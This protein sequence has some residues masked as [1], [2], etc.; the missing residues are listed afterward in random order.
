M[1]DGGE[2]HRNE[3]GGTAA[4]VAQIANLYGN[5][6]YSAPERLADIPRQNLPGPRHYTNNERQLAELSEAGPVLRLVR[7]VPGSGRSTLC[8]VH[9]AENLDRYPDGDF[10]ISLGSGPARLK[11]ALATLLGEVLPGQDLPISVEGLSARWRSWS[12]GKRIA[13]VVDNALTTAEVVPFLPGPG[14]AA[15]LAVVAGEP[16]ALI[17]DFGAAVVELE[18]LTGEVSRLLLEKMVGAD[19]LAEDAEATLRLVE[20]C[21]GS[22]AALTVVGA[23]LKQ[24]PGRTVGKLLR[25]IERQ[26]GILEK[27]PQKA[28][29][30]LAVSQLGP[31]E[32]DCYFFFGAHPGDDVSV[33]TIAD[34]LAVPQDEI[35]DACD[36]L[37]ERSLLQEV[38][39]DR[40]RMSG[41][42]RTHA[43]QRPELLPAIVASYA[44]RGWQAQSALMDRGWDRLLWPELP[45]A[46]WDDAGAWLAAERGNLAEAVRAGH[47]ARLHEDVVRL[48]LALWPIHLRGGYALEMAEVNRL[49]V[50][51]AL[52]WPSELAACVLGVQQAFA[53][54]ERRRWDE[55][56]ALLDEAGRHAVTPAAEAT[57]VETRGLVLFAQGR[58]DEAAGELRRNLDLAIAL[59]DAR[60]TAM[61]RFHLAKAELGARAI[62]LLDAAATVFEGEPVN[63]VKV[64]LWHAKKLG[65]ADALEKV[66][67][68]AAD[69]HRERAEAH[70]ALAGFGSA[71]AHLEEAQQIYLR[72]GFTLEAL[73][74]QE[75]LNGLTDA[76]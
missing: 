64:A 60:R 62:E 40:L 14:P 47:R 52:A 48:C 21:R 51:C 38:R 17:Q 31:L 30:D 43:A 65:S 3:F 37:V 63:R 4:N 10:L 59:G 57:V 55:A 20:T 18:P 68:D 67:E 22:A 9:V 29:F 8:R 66:L 34:V 16:S 70:E 12:S 19:R 75:R 76:E 72:R 26:G 25:Q 49:G 6:V 69:L 45:R 5:V 13:V 28:I 58:L 44:R 56:L 42:I 74:V 61:A 46:Q 33:E 1:T 41:L 39:G 24:S 2:S 27:L 11:D 15:V 23:L 73:D 35:E 54:R 32:R 53:A 71:R 7:G 50:E 36:V